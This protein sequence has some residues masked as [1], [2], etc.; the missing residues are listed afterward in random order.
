M[1]AGFSSSP[2]VQIAMSRFNM[3][4]Y[5]ADTQTAVLGAGLVWDDAY[6]ALVPYGVNVVGGRVA[7]I[8]IAGLTLGG[9]RS[10]GDLQC[11]SEC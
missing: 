8:G 1:N 4:D 5:D 2:G 3:I 6:A 7:G 9:G 11:S 10:A